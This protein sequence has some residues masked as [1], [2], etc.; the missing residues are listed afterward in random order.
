MIQG[1]ERASVGSPYASHRDE[2]D[3][4]RKLYIRSEECMALEQCNHA[5]T[6]FSE[7]SPHE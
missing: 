6:A 5:C 4:F 3:R 1:T 2:W 7:Q